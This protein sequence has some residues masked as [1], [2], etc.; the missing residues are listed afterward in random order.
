M[1]DVDKRLI[2]LAEDRLRAAEELGLSVSALVGQIYVCVATDEFDQ[3]CEILK[4]LDGQIN[5]ARR[6]GRDTGADR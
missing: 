6:A 3:A 5:E 2:E 4:E 1:P